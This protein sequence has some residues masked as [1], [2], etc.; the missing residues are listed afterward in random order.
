MSLSQ[1]NEGGEM[2]TAFTGLAMIGAALAMLVIAIPRR[3][4][5]VVFLRGQSVLE[6]AYTMLPVS[7]LIVGSAGAIAEWTAR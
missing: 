1:R 6:T 7:L 4:E 3:G 5:V 2:T